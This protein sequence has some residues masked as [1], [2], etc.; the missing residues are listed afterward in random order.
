M[1]VNAQQI[2]E[3]VSVEAVLQDLGYELDSRK[4]C[5]CPVH[6]GKD[7]NFSVKEGIGTCWSVCG[8]QHWDGIGLLMEVKGMTYPEALQYAAKLSSIKVEYQKGSDAKKTIEKAKEEQQLKESY[9]LL[10][11]SIMEAYFYNTYHVTQHEI[12]IDG[13]TVNHQVIGQISEEPLNWGNDRKLSWEAIQAFQI[14]QSPQDWHFITNLSD[15]FLWNKT[16]LKKN[17]VLSF[18]KNKDGSG[19]YIDR[20]VDK[21]IIP[22]HDH[23][24]KIAGF[25]VRQ[26]P[27]R[28][29]DKYPKYINSSESILYQKKQI[30]YGLWQNKR[31][32]KKLNHALLVE[33][34]FDVIS[35]WEGKIKHSVAASGTAVTLEQARLLKRYCDTVTVLMDGDEAGIKAAKRAIDVLMQVGIKVKVASL[36]EGED[37][38]SMIRKH[39]KKGFEEFLIQKSMIGLDWL[40]DSELGDDPDMFEKDSAFQQGAKIVARVEEETLRDDFAKLISKKT[41]KA[42]GVVRDKI[43]SYRDEELEKSNKKR[44]D[45]TQMSD[46]TNYGLYAEN[47]AYY[48][49]SGSEARKGTK[50]SNFVIKPLFLVRSR[51]NQRLFEITNE[52]GD[53][54]LI[55]EGTKVFVSL[56]GFNAA[57][58]N[59]GNFLFEGN[60]HQFRRLK[61][62]IY[63]EMKSAKELTV[64][65]H[66]SAGFWAWGNGLYAYKERKF[67]EA[68]EYGVVQY[69]NQYYYL[70]ALS[71]IN[72][73]LD[74]SDADAFSEEKQFIYQPTTV[75]FKKWSTQFIKV[76]NDNGKIGMLY[77]CAILFRDI[78]F[79]K[80]DFFPHIN[81]V[82]P[83]GSG[84]SFM[85]WSL[86]AMFGRPIKPFMLKTGTDVSFFNRWTRFRNGLSWFD[87]YFNDIDPRRIQYL[88]YAFDGVGR[89]KGQL[90]DNR[91][92]KSSVIS[93][94]A[95]TGQDLPTADQALFNRVVNMVYSKNE[96]TEA[97]KLEADKLKK[98]DRT[99]GLSGLTSII[100]S[101]RQLIADE[102]DQTF[103]LIYSKMFSEIKEV[104]DLPGRLLQSNCILLTVHKI[105]RDQFEFPFQ[106]EDVWNV[107]KKNMIRHAGMLGGNSET[108]EFFDV[109]QYIMINKIIQEGKEYKIRNTDELTIMINKTTKKTAKKKLDGFK[110]ILLLNFSKVHPHYLEA[111][112]KQRRK[113]QS[114]VTLMHYLKS[115]PAFVG[116]VKMVKGIGVCMAFRLDKIEIDIQQKDT[117][118]V[119]YPDGA[120]DN[121]DAP[122]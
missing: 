116:D 64:L 14:S 90:T 85:M 117:T 18:K 43:K 46:I 24:G 8:G 111:C 122:F 114:K 59:V 40:L 121:D 110:D 50:V 35:L 115:I 33:G 9:H 101:H 77:Y 55:A 4:K 11:K 56:D 23:R 28:Y 48:F 97:E 58:E 92:L 84:K 89:E 82:G 65:G 100:A 36:P 6:Q 63:Q 93:S 7:K 13:K 118:G 108:Q 113:P 81:S 74:S 57:V 16:H 27:D 86:S 98:I 53:V 3:A 29:N 106:Y 75:D 60:K 88:K 78:L 19:Q 68:D 15:E 12:E 42:L 69:D 76:H 20:F 47:F 79:P 91:S 72:Q 112:A 44:F 66:N 70:P 103:D 32:I 83:T 107:V 105:L 25:T 67:Y 31:T 52:R 45:A 51:N 80:F 95:I 102:F 37:P 54:E 119:D 87:E 96:F 10:N 38:D 73:L 62:K 26:H 34:N 30:L 61:R 39:K 109:L 17:G 120:F 22:I 21:I 99:A 2:K 104:A 94:S 41:G 5:A 71:K 1:I 49:L